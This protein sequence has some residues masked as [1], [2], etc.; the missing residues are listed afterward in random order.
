MSEKLSLLLREGGFDPLPREHYSLETRITDLAMRMIAA[1]MEGAEGIFIPQAFSDSAGVMNQDGT[2][3]E[4]FIP[5]RTAAHLLAGVPNGTYVVCFH[6]DRDPLFWE[7]IANRPPLRNGIYAIPDG[8]GWG[9]ELDQQTIARY[10]L[11]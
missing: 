2:V 9:L 10:R 11:T 1:K 8:P 7:L 5:W 6:P 4:L 3:G